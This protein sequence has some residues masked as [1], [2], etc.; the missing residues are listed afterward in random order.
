MS[1]CDAVAV[2]L[3]LN[4]ELGV[5]VDDG[6]PDADW[7][8]VIVSVRVCDWLNVIVADCDAVSLGDCEDV[9]C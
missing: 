8:R 9:S 4:V 2:R 6:L 7:L 3:E 5:R 1:V